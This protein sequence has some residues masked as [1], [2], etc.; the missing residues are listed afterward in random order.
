[1]VSRA[2]HPIFTQ[3]VLS[4]SFADLGNFVANLLDSIFH[5][6]LHQ[7]RLSNR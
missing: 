7:L 2:R 1:M 4:A 6:V 3:H 5:G